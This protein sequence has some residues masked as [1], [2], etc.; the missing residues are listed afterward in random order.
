M[1][2]QT[3]IIVVVLAALAALAWFFAKMNVG[4][5]SDL[6]PRQPGCN[7]QA[8]TASD[9]A[10]STTTPAARQQEPHV[11]YNPYLDIFNT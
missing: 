10:A 6:S 4:G 8:T 7:C 2:K 11:D 9:T 1:S 3:I 5:T